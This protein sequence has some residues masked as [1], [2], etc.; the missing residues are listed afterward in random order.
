MSNKDN[1]YFS[2]EEYNKLM[3]IIID[4]K[5]S[6][7]EEIRHRVEQLNEKIEKYIYL[8]EKQTEGKLED[9]FK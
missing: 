3:Q 9:Y 6:K 8:Y 5:N 4:N 7:D 1:I 2:R